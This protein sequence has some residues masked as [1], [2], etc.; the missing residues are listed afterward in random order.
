MPATII[1]SAFP[2]SDL[3]AVYR[4]HGARCRLEG[5]ALRR[6]DHD[7]ARRLLRCSGNAY[8]L[9]NEHGWAA[10]SYLELAL[11]ERSLGNED[12]AQEAAFESMNAAALAND[13]VRIDG[14]I[15]VMGGDIATAAAA[16]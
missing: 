9:A 3:V 1:D 13:Q 6:T 8:T 5:L 7:E 16:A 11:L 2:S 15:R 4:A 10:Q 14:A 12:A